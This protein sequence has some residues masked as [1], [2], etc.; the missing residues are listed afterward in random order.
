M[1]PVYVGEGSPLWGLSFPALAEALGLGSGSGKGRHT[2]V[3][4]PSVVHKHSPRAVG[5][6]CVQGTGLQCARRSKVHGPSPLTW[7]SPWSDGMCM[8]S[9][10]CVCPNPLVPAK[11][12]G[13]CRLS[14]HNLTYD[15]GRRGHQ[16]RRGGIREGVSS[17]DPMSASWSPSA[18]WW[19]GCPL[20]VGSVP[21]P[22]SARRGTWA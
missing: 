9:R 12:R 7:R 5:P 6:T 1:G 21:P 10:R 17:I 18:S 14:G 2:H 3:H 13:P 8:R 16:G 22:G 20:E 11:G 19:A 4:A 15:K